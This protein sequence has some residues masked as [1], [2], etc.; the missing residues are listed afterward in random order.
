MSDY[1][2]LF[3]NSYVLVL[4]FKCYNSLFFSK[5]LYKVRRKE[6]YGK[7]ILILVN[8]MYYK[9]CYNMFFLFKFY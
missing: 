7:Y 3:Y 5:V 2:D 6:D 4:F 9:K 8:L 1:K